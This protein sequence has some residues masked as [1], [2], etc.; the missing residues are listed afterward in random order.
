[1]RNLRWTW[2][3]AGL[4]C[5]HSFATVVRNWPMLALA[6]ALVAAGALLGLVSARRTRRLRRAA[7]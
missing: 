7:A 5:G 1:M 3:F 4:V 6:I 2:I